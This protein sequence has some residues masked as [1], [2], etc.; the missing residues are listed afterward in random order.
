[1][2]AASEVQVTGTEMTRQKDGVGLH[3][4]TGKGVTGKSF[5]LDEVT[6]T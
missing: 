6:E 4:D 5:Y 1:M 3:I 2:E